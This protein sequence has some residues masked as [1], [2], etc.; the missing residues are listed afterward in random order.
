MVKSVPRVVIAGRT[1]QARR[2]HRAGIH[3]RDYT[4]TE[5]TRKRYQFAVNRLLPFLED[6]SDLSA[7]D[8]IISEWIEMEWAKGTPLSYIADALSGL[9]HYW[10][11]LRG[12]L[13]ECWR[14]FKSWRRIET[15]SRAPPLTCQLARAFVAKAVGI[16]RLALATLI[17]LGFHGL[18]RTG[19]LLQLTFQDIEQ[20][21][22]CAII[23]LP[24]SKSGLRTGAKEAI[25]VRDSLTL[26]LLGTL[27]MVANHFRGQKLWPYSAQRFRTE[28]RSLC[29]SFRVAHLDFKPYSMRRGGA[30]FLLQEGVPLEAIL[31][32][33]RWKSVSVARL[34]L[35]DGL[36]LIPSLRLPAVDKTR[37]F[38]Q[39]KALTQRSVSVPSVPGACGY[40]ASLPV[41]TL[42]RWKR[43]H[44]SDGGSELERWRQ[45]S[46]A[47][48][49]ADQVNRSKCSATLW[50]AT[51]RL[52]CR[53]SETMT[54]DQQMSLLDPSPSAT[55]SEFG[56]KQNFNAFDPRLGDKYRSFSNPSNHPSRFDFIAA[57]IRAEQ[58]A[59][60]EAGRAV[61]R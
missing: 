26:N 30:T 21:S 57:R 6:Q 56:A 7:L 8:E 31:I 2:R 48:R 24:T 59:L 34:Y 27:V 46:A 38:T 13:R 28:F 47:S 23:S 44:A 1:Q 5:Q 55:S 61:T 42:N 9:H 4:I 49:E 53:A 20:N 50:A 32:R 17:A 52:R 51:R 36:S 41:D 11:Q 35:E 54:G 33:G 3:L 60:E 15:P 58:E 10:P 39:A 45:Q 19:E 29:Q 43:I 37:V 25:A 14:L 22:D 40:A 16:D 18:M 12:S